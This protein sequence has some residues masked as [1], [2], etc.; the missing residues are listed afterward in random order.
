MKLQRKRPEEDRGYNQTA[1][2]VHAE[3]EPL[4]TW[5]GDELVT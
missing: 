4:V 2:D 5:T 3:G 1:D